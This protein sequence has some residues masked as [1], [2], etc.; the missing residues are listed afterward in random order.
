MCLLLWGSHFFQSWGCWSKT[1]PILKGSSPLYLSLVKFTLK[2]LDLTNISSPWPRIFPA[3]PRWGPEENQHWDHLFSHLPKWGS[4]GHFAFLWHNLPVPWANFSLSFPQIDRFR[5][6]APRV[7]TRI[8]HQGKTMEMRPALTLKLS[9]G[10][11]S[12]ARE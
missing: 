1:G 5:N 10:A 3:W 8:S 2:F 4:P 12:H 7:C 11:S 6:N 9:S